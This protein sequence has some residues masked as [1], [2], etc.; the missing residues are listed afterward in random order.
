[1]L[2]IIKLSHVKENKNADWTFKGCP[3]DYTKVDKVN[4]KNHSSKAIFTQLE[5]KNTESNYHSSMS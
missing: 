4:K 2:C 1:M 5:V 3:K